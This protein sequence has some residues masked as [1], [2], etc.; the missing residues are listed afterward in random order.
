MSRKAG[1]KLSVLEAAAVRA[2]M[3][4]PKQTL[5]SV[6]ALLIPRLGYKISHQTLNAWL[7][8]QSGFNELKHK[9][10]LM[11]LIGDFG[12]LERMRAAAKMRDFQLYNDIRSLG[13]EL[14]PDQP[15][16]FFNYQNYSL[17]LNKLQPTEAAGCREAKLAEMCRERIELVAAIDAMPAPPAKAVRDSDHITSIPDNPQAE[18]AQLRQINERLRLK[19]LELEEK[20]KQLD[21]L[22]PALRALLDLR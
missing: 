15:A 20:Q 16:E 22:L 4:E 12:E 13:A 18:I 9:E 21:I 17:I 19:N 11:K 8:R 7:K 10:E 6:V 2:W 5:R 14:L 3:Q 1:P